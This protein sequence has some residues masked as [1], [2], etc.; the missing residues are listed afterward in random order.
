MKSFQSV[1]SKNNQKITLVI[2]AETI[3][4]ARHKLHSQGY[5]VIEIEEYVSNPSD[6]GAMNNFFYFDA[7]VWGERKS[8]Q[9]QSNDIFKAYKKLVEDLGYDILYIYTTK[10]A[11][12]EQKKLLTLQVK[13]SY[14]IYVKQQGE[15]NIDKNL[16]KQH[17]E[18]V[19]NENH[20]DAALE[21]E[22]IK[23][24]ALIE[25][26]IKK[27]ENIN[28]NYAS[29]VPYEKREKLEQ[30][31]GSLM[32]V[33]STTNVSKLKLIGE[34]SMKKIW[35]LEIDLIKQNVFK[36]KEQQIQETNKLLKQFGSSDRFNIPGQ[37]EWL[38]KFE[39]KLNNV[40]N[41]VFN[42]I[43]EKKEEESKKTV[44]TNT[45]VF[46]KNLRELN[47][48]K[49]KLKEVNHDIILARVQFQA[50]R[51]NRLNLKRR[52]IEQNIK[53]LE[54]RL[55]NSTFSYTKIVKWVHYYEDLFFGLIG[56][57][58]DTILYSIFIFSWVFIFYITALSFGIEGIKFYENF[59][60]FILLI[61]ILA[62]YS[63]FIKWYISLA[64]SA[65]FYTI[66]TYF[67]LINF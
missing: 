16:L 62:F 48:Y 12:D 4:D 11:T 32:Q 35:E 59:M 10:N 30:I 41:T 61:A 44:D 29:Y 26:V 52:L 27:I 39:E 54:N 19:N 53:L 9:I 55:K 38:K 67:I 46:Y 57:I 8:G 6:M 33:R 43:E 63:R 22:I 34:T 58:S 28:T 36:E 1:C 15:S 66:S 60:Y 56:T 21:K 64:F 23:Y 51:I 25:V 13:E 14:D 37:E 7:V 47:L 2:Q 20:I 42:K 40:F 24:V 17:E 5:S 3:E 31:R 18:K 65:V 45:F 50:D 49:D